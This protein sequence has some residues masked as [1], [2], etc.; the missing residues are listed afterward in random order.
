M[1]RPSIW[2]DKFDRE[3]TFSVNHPFT[4]GGKKFAAGDIFDKTLVTTRRLRQ[5]YDKRL[6][7]MRPEQSADL[8]ASDGNITVPVTDWTQLSW[9]AMRKYV[10]EQT[11]VWPSNKAQATELMEA[12]LGQSA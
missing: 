8:L 10:A 6:L 1:A 5:L 7:L 9:L 2:Q 4:C 3:R 11:G 12:K